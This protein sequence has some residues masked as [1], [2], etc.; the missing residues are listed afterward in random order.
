MS[1]PIKNQLDSQDNATATFEQLVV[2]IINNTN[3]RL[4][5][6]T[7]KSLDSTQDKLF[8]LSN[9]ADSNVDQTRYFELT[10]QIRS[11][12][13]DIAVDFSINIK[14]YLV[15]A[16][17]FKSNQNNQE[18]PDDAELSLVDQD[19]MEG[20][21]LVKGIGERTAAKYSEQLSQLA[22]RFKELYQKTNNIFISD[23][24]DPT[25]FCQ[26]FDDALGH[27]FSNDDK[28]VLFTMFESNV[29]NNLDEFYQNINRLLIEAG[30][31][32]TIKLAA[33]VAP[34]PSHVNEHSDNHTTENDQT[35]GGD[36]TTDNSHDAGANNISGFA[37]TA[38]PG[39]NYRNTQQNSSPTTDANQANNGSA[40]YQHQTAGMPASQVVETLSDFIGAPF[41]P[42]TANIPAKENAA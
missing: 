10:N 42:E 35:N 6:L 21:V 39:S 5:E 4:S 37:M 8:N 40:G 34:Q 29:I 15:P 9:E 18:L 22:L 3:T 16:S 26:A 19:D 38:A 31:L 2:E 28:K 33:A 17:K 1:D 20:I 41:S 27:H 7:T 32:P 30:I 25:N 14:K 12:K 36:Q 24:L 11:L 13:S 23:A